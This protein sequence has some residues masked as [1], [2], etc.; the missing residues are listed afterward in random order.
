MIKSFF[1]G[2]TALSLLSPGAPA[3]PQP[4]GSLPVTEA[5]VATAPD[6]A[7]TDV[8]VM[9]SDQAYLQQ[10]LIDRSQRMAV[11][12]LINGQGPWPFVVDTG[13]ERTIISR[14]L[15]ER[16][17]LIP[18]A[19]L[20]LSTLSG[21]HESASYDIAALSTANVMM[22]NVRAPALY[23]RNLG[24]AGLL[25]IDSLQHRRVI[26]DFRRRHM[27]LRESARNEKPTVRDDDTIVVTA[28]SKSG[29]LILTDASIGGTKIHLIVDTGTQRS[30]GNMALLDL[31]IRRKQHAFAP[32]ESAITSV[33]GRT[34][35]ARGT[36]LK[37]LNL[38]GSTIVDLPIDFTDAH[39]FQTLGLDKRPAMLMGM[40][41]LQIFDRIEIDFANRRVVFDM[42]DRADGRPRQR[43]AA[44]G[45][46]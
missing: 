25:G 1:A 40:D 9:V 35:T 14:E 10:F 16:L 7:V 12:V 2:L 42:P 20:Y 22:T 43:F 38:Q 13:S 24:S 33:T 37:K 30:V 45:V 8:P 31:I 15:A 18:G 4:D 19:K 44:L 6:T 26:F 21:R 41:A 11:D 29:R 34:V 39:A 46:R 17:E 27:E 23:A 32:V 36:V 3:L 28:R 5:P